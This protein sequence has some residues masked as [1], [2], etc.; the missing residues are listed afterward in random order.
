[1]SNLAFARAEA[2]SNLAV[3]Y[4]KVLVGVV[5]DDNVVHSSFTLAE[6]MV[7]E[8]EKRWAE[9]DAK[10]QAAEAEKQRAEKFKVSNEELQRMV[11]IIIIR[12]L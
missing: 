7:A 6:R 11:D 10:V 2:V 12:G 3:E 9:V 4:S 5:S 8:I 1:M